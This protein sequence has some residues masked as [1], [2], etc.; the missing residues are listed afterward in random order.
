MSEYCHINQACISVGLRRKNCARIFAWS[1]LILMPTA[2]NVQLRLLTFILYCKLYGAKVSL[3]S[4]LE[5]PVFSKQVTYVC[6]LCGTT[7]EFRI[8][9]CLSATL[10]YNYLSIAYIMNKHFR[11]GQL[12]TCCEIWPANLHLVPF[13]LLKY[14]VPKCTSVTNHN[15][16]HTNRHHSFSG[17]TA[18][19]KRFAV[20]LTEYERHTLRCRAVQI[21]CVC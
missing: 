21:D 3:H 18:N 17:Y 13:L 7:T 9:H 1:Q 4:R 10:Y 14:L 5:T 11:T 19:R 20:Q 8:S 16:T 2:N 6:K 15:Y 12:C